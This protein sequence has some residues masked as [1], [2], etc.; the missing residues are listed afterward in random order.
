[1]EL[2]RGWA[3]TEEN[4]DGLWES[5]VTVSSKRDAEHLSSDAIGSVR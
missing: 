4:Q 1:M 2:A 5:D 3:R